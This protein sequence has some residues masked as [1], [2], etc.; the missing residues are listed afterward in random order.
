MQVKY[1]GGIVA[2]SILLNTGLVDIFLKKTKSQKIEEMQNL[3]WYF[4]W[5]Y[6][7]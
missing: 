7:V 4:A 6:V 5:Q 2:K 3:Y 1:K